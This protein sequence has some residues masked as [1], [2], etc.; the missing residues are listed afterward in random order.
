MRARHPDSEGFVESDGLS[1]GYE[2]FGEGDVTLLLLPTW[3]IIHSRFWKLQVPYLARH[4]RVLTYDGPGN[5]RSDRSLDPL[6]YS[7]EAQA[8]YALDVM[9]ATN[10][11]RAVVVS[12]SM[13]S[14][15]SLRL[16][17]NQ[18]D[19]VL[20]QVFIDPT[21]PITPPTPAR[22]ESAQAFWLEQDDPQGWEKYNAHYWQTNYEDFVEFFFSQWFPEP[23]STKPLE[24]CVG[25]GLETTPQVLVAKASVEAVSQETILDWCRR[26]DSPV[27]VIHGDD[28]R[29]SPLSR[30]R[31]LAEAT[32]GSLAVVEGGGHGTLVRDPVV[33]N[34]LIKEFTD[35]I[36]GPLVSPI[37]WTHG[38]NRRKRALYIS[39][40]IGLGHARRDLAIAKE[41][42][43]LDPELEI[44]WLAQ[45]PVTR[46]LEAEGETI[47]PASEWLASESAHIASEATGHD[48]HCFQALR[49]MDEI[50]VANFMIFQ[51]IMDEGLYDV[52]IGDEAW[53]IDHFWHENPELKRGDHVWMT[54]FVG[55]L[56]MPS[57]GEHEVYL[58]ADYNAEMIEHISRYPRI[59]DL[60]MFVGRPDDI[61]PE[62]F[63]PGLPKIRDW[64][65]EHFQFTGYITGFDAPTD[66]EMASWRSDLGY[67]EDEKVCVVTVGGSGV[68]RDLL[69]KVIA[70][71]PVAKRSMPELRMIVVAG[72]R[73]DPESLPTHDGLEYHGYVH[74]LYRHLA[75]CDL[76]VVQGG[77]TTTMELT[78]ARTPFL[79]FPLRNHFEQ[80]YHVRHRLDRYRAGT[81][82][83]YAAVDPDAIADEIVSRAG[84]PV[85]YLPVETGGAAK[86]AALIAELI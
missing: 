24:D 48:L 49:R 52:A 43:K 15:W 61:V 69:E 82:M 74:G 66:D 16:A 57:G 54:D 46:V 58:T 1:I 26:I 7:A 63:G 47:H 6:R 8:S 81:Y 76:A 17:A 40:P 19:R 14:M 12:L 20:G 71:Y 35:R 2:V 60:S 59:R 70:A 37:R 32:G 42:R 18:P 45:D 85:D 72:P 68:G 5:G 38:L 22:A 84:A 83:D 34:R 23:H 55:Y 56:P 10:T 78:A 13:A 9:D 51:E 50:L 62:V 67:R 21:L 11:E 75:A 31:R 30:G 28:D 64:T 79:Y 53:D 33:V 27:L 80:N 4:S 86:A 39:S 29:V 36:S 65:E 3:T 44:D 41:L 77:L 73:I 25:W